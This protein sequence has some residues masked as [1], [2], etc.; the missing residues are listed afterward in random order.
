MIADDSGLV[1][2]AL[3]GAPGVHSARYAGPGASDADRIRKLLGEM[4]GKKGEE[5]PRA[6]CVRHCAGRSGRSRAACFRRPPKE[7]SWRR[8]AERAASA[9]IRFSSFLPWEKH[10][11]KFRAKKRISTAIAEKPFARRSN[12]SW[13]Y[14]V[15]P[16]RPDVRH[17]CDIFMRRI[18]MNTIAMK[19]QKS[20]N[21]KRASQDRKETEILLA[22]GVER[23]R[24]RAGARKAREPIRSACARSCKS[25][26]KPIR[27]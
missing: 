13:H 4:R 2:P 10:T 14:A 5:P 18:E 25:W 20:K 11:R 27:T 1:V 8:R 23:L 26:T 6:V 17:A 24:A 21:Q 19:K 15:G 7:K 12:F 22:R 9:T 16:R 3:G